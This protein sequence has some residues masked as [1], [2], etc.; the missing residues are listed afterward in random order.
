M[1]HQITSK[2][3][4][5]STELTVV[6]PLKQGLVE[7]LG[8]TKTYATRLRALL[9]TLN[10]IRKISVE[11]RHVKAYTDPIE[12]LRTINDFRWCIFDNDTR[13]LLAVTFDS[14]WETYIRKI[15]DDAGPLLDVILC[16]CEGYEEY[17]STKGYY[18]FA[19]WA[20]KHQIET[21]FF[22]SATGDMTVDDM[23]Y[24]KQ[25]EHTQRNTANPANFDTAA[26][27]LQAINIEKAAQ[28][29][30]QQKKHI[31][32]DQGLSTLE[33]MFQ[34]A[35]YFENSEQDKRFLHAA[36]KAILQEFDSKA[37]VPAGLRQHHEKALH[38]FENTSSENSTPA[39]E[40]L[41]P[42]D[43]QGDLLKP[44]RKMTHSCLLLMRVLDQ[45]GAAKLFKDKAFLKHFEVTK[46][47][48]PKTD[49]AM[50]IA[51]TYRGLQELG[52]TNEDLSKF[53]VDFREGMEARAGVLGDVRSNHPKKL[54]IT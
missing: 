1:Q 39:I 36:T 38:W 25:L 29:T 45:A 11:E 44:Y 51:F 12:R 19:E 52:L 50:N 13:L 23:Q 16:H 48:A 31:A 42:T 46:D 49:I 32:L 3:L 8:G 35:P 4:G 14:A 34:L 37:L 5:T 2:Y 40:D 10:Q 27:R 26:A 33:A 24:L 21:D 30:A 15:A 53:P 18:R 22:Y 28:Q 20:R 9:R 54:E 7:A 47:G 6:M 43:I 17:A 41:Q